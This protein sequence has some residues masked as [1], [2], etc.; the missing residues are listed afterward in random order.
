MVVARFGGYLFT[1]FS[2]PLV[3]DGRHFIVERGNLPLLTVVMEV[4]GRPLFDILKNMPSPNDAVDVSADSAGV[5]TVS[6]RPSGTYLYKVRPGFETSVVFRK[7]D[8]GKCRALITERDIQIGG[9]I[10]ENRLFDGFLGGVIV[11][12]QIGA[13]MLGAPLP[14]QIKD[15]LS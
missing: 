13:G 15:W 3:F 1:D 7:E 6:E 5:I 8:G 12:P 11:D 2:V 14:Q 10:V 4:N 9:L